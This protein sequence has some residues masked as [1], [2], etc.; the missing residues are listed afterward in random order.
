MGDTMLR[1]KGRDGSP[2]RPSSGRFRTENDSIAPLTNARAGADASVGQ[3][4][5]SPSTAFPEVI[6]PPTDG[7]ASRPYP[8]L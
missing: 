2:S 5:S 6:V 3:C 8:Y 7:S 1:S 4:R